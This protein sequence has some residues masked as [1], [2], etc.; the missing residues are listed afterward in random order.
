[1]PGPIIAAFKG[2]AG[3]DVLAFAAPLSRASGRPLM[4]AAVYPGRAPVGLG[5]VDAEWVAYNRDEADS[6]LDE[7]R[8][9][10]GDEPGVDYRSVAAD[11]ASHGLHDLLE[12]S[13]P[14]AV[15]VLGSSNAKGTRRTVVGSTADRL[16]QGA[17][18][19]VVIVPWAYEEYAA[20]AVT[21]IAVAYV[22][23]PDGAA[24]L[25]FGQ[26]L[27]AE[28]G[29]SLSLI[30]VLPDTQVRPSLGDRTG[31]A[32][33]QRAAFRAA[34]EQAAASAGGSSTLLEGPVVDALT[35]LQPTDVDL[36]VVG[37]RGYGP[38]RRV[39]LGGVSSRVLKQAKVPVLVVPRG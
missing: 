36:L 18:G 19:P 25:A 7:A 10:L 24:A 20:A 14:T 8:G 1:M 26:A 15:A 22:A 21:R 17:P 2:A 16:L 30:S 35:G 13:G 3:P 32:A 31:F 34:V 23:T 27:A 11:S 38:A 29:A 28:L 37:S 12:Q 9:L 33:E 4:V 6:L 39:L 5:R